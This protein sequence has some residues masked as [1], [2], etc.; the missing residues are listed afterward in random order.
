[1]NPLI[2]TYLI[3][4]LAL[5]VLVILFSLTV[6]K[7]ISTEEQ[8]KLA[9][10]FKFKQLNL[11]EPVGV[12]PASIRNVHPQY[13]SI[14]AWISSVG[15]GVAFA[16][17]DGDGLPN[18]LIHVDPRYDKVFVEPAAGTETA[19]HNYNPYTLDVKTLP[20]DVTTMAPMGT[21]ADDFNEDGK[22]DVLVY[23]WGRTP[24]IFY[25]TENGY[26]ENELVITNTKYNSNT[27][28]LADFDGDG[29][30]DIFIGNYFPDDGKVLDAKATD[31]DQV[32][33]HG[34]SRADNGA[35]NRMFL[36]NGIENGITKFE[37]SKDWNKGIDNPKDWT[38]AVGA[39]DINGDLLPEIYV[40]NDFG[41]DK[42]LYN[43]STPGH[44]K[45]KQLFGVKHFRTINS[46]VVGKDSYKGMGVAFADLNGDGLLDIYVSNIAEEYALF[47]SHFAF[48]CTGEFDKMKDGYA[49]FVNKSE[50][51][52]LSRSY[53][54]W[55]AKLGDFNNDGTLEAM[56]ATGFIKGE[57]NRW[58]ELQELAMGND[59]LLP[60]TE[61]WAN[62]TAGTDLSGGAHIPFFVKSKSGK[63]FDLA[64][65]VGVG[66]NQI[67]RGIAMA[68]ME[69]DGDLDFATAD[70]WE[71]SHLYLNDYAGKNSFLGL[72]L[73]FPIEKDSV[74]NLVVDGNAKGR[75]AIGASVK[76]K[77]PD[78]KTLTS[79]VDGGNGHSGKNAS[80][81]FLGLG[82]TST[83]QLNVEIKWRMANGKE[84]SAN[85]TTTAGW[86]KIQLPY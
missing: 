60:K 80:E 57:T 37:E 68:D 65:N 16:D 26:I 78:G 56:Q 22:M 46:T 85:I 76:V 64:M 45:F 5:L 24:V 33:Q 17:M 82:S 21:L 50:E 29:H 10:E 75:Y 61:S 14:D 47:E 3:K 63:Y 42:L 23:Y 86:H 67:T 71:P 43:Q 35:I 79:F 49:P 28:T 7:S 34:M 72:T 12:T 4:A 81:I 18:D 30:I 8:N 77:L 62:F 55:D 58:A 59:D 13:K 41:E 74:N 69:H 84:N 53:W 9:S 20:Y 66:E 52:G 51:M 48:M 32:M 83:E 6:P 1:M 15:A 27:G 2:K 19:T 70:Q 25:Q 38:L 31:H 54:S 39:A 40:A 36:W 73:F 44:P 11:Y